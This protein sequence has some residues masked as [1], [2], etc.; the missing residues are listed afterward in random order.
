M[1]KEVDSE[2]AEKEL[3]KVEAIIL[4]MTPQERHNH[5]ML[6]GS[7]RKRIAKGSGTS[8]EDINKLIKQFAQMKTVMQQLTKGGMGGM[9]SML[10]KSPLAGLSKKFL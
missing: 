6:N 2:A 10:G 7:R 3:K 9:M 8:V 5:A 4:S 1:T